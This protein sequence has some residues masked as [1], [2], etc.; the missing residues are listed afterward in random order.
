VLT[1]NIYITL[2]FQTKRTEELM[3]LQSKMILCLHL[4]LLETKCNI[5]GEILGFWEI[6]EIGT[7][8]QRKV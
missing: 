4:M 5:E 1:N 6:M 2:R 3:P 8:S 7:V